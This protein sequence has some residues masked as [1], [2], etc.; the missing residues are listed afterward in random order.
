MA[1]ELKELL[2]KINEEGV[3]AAEEKAAEIRNKA[4]SQA[5]SI[6]E[7]ANDRARDIVE[8]AGR[9]VA[10]ME[11]G[12]KAALAQASRDMLIS[13]RKEITAMLDKIVASHV[14]KALE[15]GE[16]AKIIVALVREHG[17][18]AEADIIVTMK[19]DDLDKLGRSFLAE[20]RDEIKKGITL[21]SSDEIHGGFMI[22]YDNGKSYY[23]FTDKAIAKYVSYGLRPKLAEILNSI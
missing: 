12:G 19:K 1:E 9:R 17:K 16:L 7:D 20:L 13:L 15:H 21:G 18:E 14:H 2:E 4:E 5:R 22:S 11:A 8:S 10:D 6:I 3:K 23:D